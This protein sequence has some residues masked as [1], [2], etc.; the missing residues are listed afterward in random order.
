M[1]TANIS[2]SAEKNRLMV[3]GDLN[4]ST[5]PLLWQKSLPLMTAAQDLNFDFTQIISSNSAGLALLIEWIK[6]AKTSGKKVVFSNIPAQLQSIIR[7]AGVGD[8]FL[9]P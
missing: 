3:S 6:F 1:E 8:M 9:S 5:V 7:A 4:F 2:A